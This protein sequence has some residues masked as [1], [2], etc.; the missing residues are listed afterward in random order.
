MKHLKKGRKLNRVAKQRKA[1]L[2]A[3]A[4][5]L[6]E[7]EKIVTT[8][9][10]AKELRPYI[11]KFITRAKEKSVANIRYINRFLPERSSKKLFDE[12]AK[13]YTERNGGY[14]RIIKLPPRKSDS[15]KMAKIEFV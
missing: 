15:A 12:V 2:K 4:V 7:N 6:I 11:E 1:L 13:R 9:A 10:K 14:T 3:L 8:E 5:A